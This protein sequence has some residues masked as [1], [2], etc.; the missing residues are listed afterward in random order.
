MA[1]FSLAFGTAT[2]NRD[3]KIIEAFFP[4]PLLNPSDALVAAVAEVSGYSEGN[5]AIEISAAQSAELAKAFA[6]N[7]DAANASFAEK[8]QHL[9]NLLFLLFLRLTRSQHLLLKAS[10]S[11]NLSLTA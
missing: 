1:Y 9:S 3:N 6:A 4:N 5:Q 10:L 7:D 2:K 8:Q 11:Y